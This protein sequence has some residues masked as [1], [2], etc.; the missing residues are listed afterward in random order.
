[1]TTSNLVDRWVEDIV[2]LAEDARSAVCV[3]RDLHG[4]DWYL[5]ILWDRQAVFVNGLSNAGANS[6]TTLENA[7][8]RFLEL[9][10]ADHNEIVRR[11]SAAPDEGVD[12]QTPTE[13]WWWRRVP[14]RGC[15]AAELERW[16]PE[17]Q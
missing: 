11:I 3:H 5:G 6:A 1:M 13:P 10:V 16:F 17:G 7:D 2:L 8:R 14:A 12:S 9:T 15:I 4:P